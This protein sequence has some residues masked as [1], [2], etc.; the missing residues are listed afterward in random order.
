MAQTL[1]ATPAYPH[2]AVDA[3]GVPFLAG[4]TIKVVELVMAQQAYGWSP[5]ELHFQ[6]PD[7][8]LSHIYSALAYY[9]DHREALD[10]DIERRAERVEQIR[11]ESGPSDLAAKVRARAREL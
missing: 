11:R 7:I 5:E 8:P 6:H 2:V 4:T 1:P 3:A 9:W 10:R